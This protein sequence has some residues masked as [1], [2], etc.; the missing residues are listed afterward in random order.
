[1]QVYTFLARPSL[2]VIASVDL[3]STVST[4]A[5]LKINYCVTQKNSCSYKILCIQ[6]LQLS[7]SMTKNF[8][9]LNSIT[10]TTNK[11]M[12]SYFMH[13]RKR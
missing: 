13:S 1:M 8:I 10:V 9:I 2:A 5:A 3:Q 12:L 7:V 4:K 6:H 11:I